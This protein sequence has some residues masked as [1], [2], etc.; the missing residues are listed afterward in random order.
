[1]NSLSNVT[2]RVNVV[3]EAE[4]LGIILSV[5]QCRIV[6]N[7]TP[8][9]RV[10]K[11]LFKP[12][13]GF[14]SLLLLMVVEMKG[15]FGDDEDVDEGDTNDFLTFCSLVISIKFQIK[16]QSCFKLIL[17][18]ATTWRMDFD[19]SFRSSSTDDDDDE[20]EEKKRRDMS[21]NASLFRSASRTRPVQTHEAYSSSG[22]G[23]ADGVMFLREMRELAI[24]SSIDVDDPLLKRSIA[25]ESVVVAVVVVPVD[26]ESNRSMISGFRFFFLLSRREFLLLKDL[27]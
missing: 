17:F 7:A 10:H 3:R 11:R 26:N 27:M 13:V 5:L 16:S 14:V 21:V 25:H 20:D 4:M 24:P 1:M 12:S 8:A 18:F 15:F 9:R 6:K 19:K 2:V 22:T 23:F